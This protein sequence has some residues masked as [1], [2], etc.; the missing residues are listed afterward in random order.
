MKKWGP[1]IGYLLALFVVVPV[2]A[3]GVFSLGSSRSLNLLLVITG[4]LT[5]WVVGMLMAPVSKSEAKHF[6]EYGKAISTFAAG[7]LVA[8]ADKLFDLYFKD[9]SAIDEL[10]IGRLA[11]FVSA[12]AVGAL[13]TYVW[14]MYVSSGGEELP[15][16]PAHG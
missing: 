6:P 2:I 12:F 4:A 16:T 7:Y 1:L 3:G 10:L 14:R 11:M 15:K 9:G 13:S 8:K 5:G